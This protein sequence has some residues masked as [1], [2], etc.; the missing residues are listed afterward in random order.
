MPIIPIVLCRAIW[1][2]LRN[3]RKVK[4]IHRGALLLVNVAD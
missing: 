1:Y 4:I 2:H 3:L